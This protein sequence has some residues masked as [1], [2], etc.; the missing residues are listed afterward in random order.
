MRNIADQRH[1]QLLKAELGAPQTG[2]LLPVKLKLCFLS[3]S[4]TLVKRAQSASSVGV[5]AD[6]AFFRRGRGYLLSNT[7]HNCLL[8][9]G[10][11]DSFAAGTSTSTLP[12]PRPFLP[13]G[14][15]SAPFSLS[16]ALSRHMSSRKRR[17]L[18]SS[19][20]AVPSTLL[21]SPTVFMPASI[22]LP[23]PAAL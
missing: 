12:R 19:A 22:P 2:L 10:F 15:F 14:T 3:S 21:P 18:F 13:S 4:R 5:N 9:S 7:S 1:F 23:L 20:A 16:A 8:E 6:V 11:D 17:I